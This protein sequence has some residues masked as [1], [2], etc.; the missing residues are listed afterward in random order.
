MTR[1]TEQSYFLFLIYDMN[2]RYKED[3]SSF[4]DYTE[5]KTVHPTP[6]ALSIYRKYEKKLGDIET[7]PD[8]F[9][10]LYGGIYVSKM[11][12]GYYTIDGCHDCFP[13]THYKGIKELY[14]DHVGKNAELTLRNVYECFYD[15][16]YDCFLSDYVDYEDGEEADK[17]KIVSDFYNVIFRG[18]NPDDICNKAWNLYRIYSTENMYNIELWPKIFDLILEENFIREEEDGYHVYYLGYWPKEKFGSYEEIY[19]DVLGW[20]NDVLDFMDVWK[21][22]YKQY[23]YQQDM[24]AKACEDY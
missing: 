16:V 4:L 12:P 2:K 11:G 19:R 15:G 23:I 20:E 10:D 6:K 22:F 8:I 9:G 18:G 1:L 14:Q 5:G 7:W 21:R 3:I 13:K 17:D 24:I